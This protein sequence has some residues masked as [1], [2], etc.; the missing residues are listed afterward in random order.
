MNEGVKSKNTDNCHSVLCAS[1]QFLCVHLSPSQ[2]LPVRRSVQQLPR[3]EAA[4][5]LQQQ[6]RGLLVPRLL[7]VHHANYL[8]ATRPHDSSVSF[9]KDM[10]I[11]T[12][13][14]FILCILG[15]LAQK[16][17]QPE[18]VTRFRALKTIRKC[19]PLI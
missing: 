6:G 15:S 18:N 7:Q 10:H 11:F 9:N 19:F 8:N 5:G 14:V 13:F 17:P 3:S 12:A 1:V 2:P 4:V 16:Q